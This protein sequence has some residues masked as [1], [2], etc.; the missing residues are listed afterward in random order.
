MAIKTH[1]QV[2]ATPRGNAEGV[3]MEWDTFS[4]L[5]VTAPKGFLACGIF[6]VDA[7]DCYGRAAA[8]VVG[9]PDNPI[10]TL[11]RFMERHI[12]RAN[13]RAHA[14]GITAGMP[15]G[16]ALEKLF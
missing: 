6:D 9:A 4:L 10:G 14:L 16:K 12:A 2:I 1:V 3:K 11:E 5:M 13:N 8:L 7:I 15:V